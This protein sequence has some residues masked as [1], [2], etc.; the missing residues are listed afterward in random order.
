MGCVASRAH[1][2]HSPYGHPSSLVLTRPRPP[3]LA[4][5]VPMLPTQALGAAL[6][7]DDNDGWHRRVVQDSDLDVGSSSDE[8][9]NGFMGHFSDHG[10]YGYGSG[11]AGDDS[12]ESEG[13]NDG[14]HVYYQP[15]PDAPT[16]TFRT[17]GFGA[18]P[19]LP[20]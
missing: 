5:T 20:E 7:D 17:P 13:A 10:S 12:D 4:H 8:D 19:F 2:Y 9:G 1:D 16:A 14:L 6:Y 15:N 3:P 11:G 18:S